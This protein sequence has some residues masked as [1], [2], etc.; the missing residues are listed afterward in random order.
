MDVRV[1]AKSRRD[2]EPGKTNLPFISELLRGGGAMEHSL[3]NTV[4]LPLKQDEQQG[5]TGGSEMAA[6]SRQ[7]SYLKIGM[8]Y[9]KTLSRKEGAK[10]GPTRHR[11]FRLTEVALEYFHLFSTVR[12][13]KVLTKT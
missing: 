12:K 8:L 2:S 1:T 6:D 7:E 10:P 3:V 5:A 11:Q 9:K 13:I 4:E